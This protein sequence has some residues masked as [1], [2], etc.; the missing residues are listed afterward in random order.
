MG[1]TN[2]TDIY[3]GPGRLKHPT[4]I[5][6]LAEAAFLAAAERNGD[7]YYSAA[8]APIFRNEGKNMTQWTPDLLSFNPGQMVKST[9]YWIQYA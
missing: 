8:Y 1:L 9:S 2:D 4:L 6:A 5:G 7:I 3:S